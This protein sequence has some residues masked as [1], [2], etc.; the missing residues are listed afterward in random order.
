MPKAPETPKKTA[1]AAGPPRPA[2]VE[3]VAASEEKVVAGIVV[4][5]PAGLQ[6]PVQDSVMPMLME[7]VIC[8]INNMLSRTLSVHCAYQHFNFQAGSGLELDRW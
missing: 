3:P 1:S 2:S 6:L 7:V 8:C 4:A 5:P